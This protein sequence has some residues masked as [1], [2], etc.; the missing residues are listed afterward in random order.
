[1]LT[2]EAYFEEDNR[3]DSPG[4]TKGQEVDCWFRWCFLVGGL[5]DRMRILQVCS[6]YVPAYHC[7]GALYGA[8]PG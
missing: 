8:F 2:V 5:I 1:M 4:P 6:H 7:G 3:A